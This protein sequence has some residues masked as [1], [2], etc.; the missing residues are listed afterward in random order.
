M[1]CNIVGLFR[2][3]E[4]IVGPLTIS[5]S[6][7]FHAMLTGTHVRSNQKLFCLWGC[8]QWEKQKCSWHC[9]M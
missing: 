8:P 4:K 5:V 2:P 3:A 9:M 6:C 7:A 1:V